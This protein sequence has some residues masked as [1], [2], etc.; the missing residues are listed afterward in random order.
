MLH[1][2]AYH[3]TDVWF[4]LR[5]WCVSKLLYVVTIYLIAR[6]RTTADTVSLILLFDW[7]YDMNWLCTDIFRNINAFRRNVQEAQRVFN[8]QSVP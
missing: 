4:N 6:L 1:F 3:S 5:M 2:I 8:L 7:T